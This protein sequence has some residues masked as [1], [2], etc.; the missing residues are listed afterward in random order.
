MAYSR[1]R[2]K[3]PYELAGTSAVVRECAALVE[4]AAGDD[5]NVLIAAEPGLD[6][7]A[8]ASAIHQAG[9]GK[10]GPFVV[11]SC[12]ALSAA[13][14]ERA[15]FGSSRRTAAGDVDALAASSALFRAREGVL[16]VTDLEELPASLQQRLSRLL[17]DGEVK[18]PRRSGPVALDVRL[19]A[20]TS[21]R[22]DPG[23]RED[24]LRRL[25]LVIEIPSFRQRRDDVPAIAE[26]M[27]AARDRRRRFT[28]A[29][30]TV[31]SALPWRRNTAE[32]AGLLD[33]LGAT[34]GF[35]IRQEDVLAE[36]QLDRAPARPTGTLR[37]ARRAFEREFIAGVLRDHS[38][39]MRDAAR[40]LGIE[41]ANLYRKARQLGIP[42]RR[43]GSAERRLSG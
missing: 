19:I 29:A 7:G 12:A 8:V 32:L 27:L 37:D 6:A 11:Q 3:L 31:L 15:L 42:L 20:S 18:V 13:E 14:L 26:A 17:R 41:R 30:L 4:R 5:R 33:R 43:E 39:Q 22:L 2:M 35:V 40:A 36:V 24:L 34:G 16:F 28:P 9:T 10:A 25:P 21:N 38:W 23:L 1:S